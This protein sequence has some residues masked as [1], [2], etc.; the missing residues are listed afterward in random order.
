MQVWIGARQVYITPSCDCSVIATL[1]SGK[2]EAGRQDCKNIFSSRQVH[3]AGLLFL[4]QRS[5]VREISL[6]F[7]QHRSYRGFLYFT[8]VDAA[9]HLSEWQER[10]A[11]RVLLLLVYWLTT[12]G[13][14]HPM[15]LEEF[16]KGF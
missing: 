10:P 5:Y 11:L 13:D 2:T 14:D 15:A 8:R 1:L 12:P 6:T 7:V 16:V 9:R 3:K 4:P